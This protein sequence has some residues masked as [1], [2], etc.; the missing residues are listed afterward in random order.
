MNEK[1]Y[2]V[3]IMANSTQPV[4]KEL[5][6]VIKDLSTDIKL[7]LNE[8]KRVNDKILFKLDVQNDKLTERVK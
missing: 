3:I 6:N 7:E 5:T 4:I 8:L 1:K 2:K